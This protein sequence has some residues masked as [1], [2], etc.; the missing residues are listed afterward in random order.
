LP[1]LTTGDLYAKIGML[2]VQID[3]LQAEIVK[4]KEEAGGKEA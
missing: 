1:S 2:I 3:L 4:L